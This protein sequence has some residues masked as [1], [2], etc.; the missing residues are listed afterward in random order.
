MA[1]LTMTRRGWATSNRESRVRPASACRR[2]R[3]TRRDR[4]EGDPGPV[5]LGLSIAVDPDEPA[6]GRARD[7]PHA[8]GRHRPDAG[9][10][11]QTVP[12]RRRTGAARC[13]RAALVRR[14]GSSDTSS[15]PPRSNPRLR[16]RSAARCP[17]YRFPTLTSASDSATCATT[18]PLPNRRRERGGAPRRPL[19]ARRGRRARTRRTPARGRRASGASTVTPSREEQRRASIGTHVQ[20]R[21]RPE[22]LR[23]PAA[24]SA[25]ATAP[26][27]AAASPTGARAASSSDSVSSC[28]TRRKRPAPSETR[29]AISC[30]RAA[31]RARSMPPRLA[32]ASSS[33]MTDNRHQEHSG[34][35]NCWVQRRRESRARRGDV[36]FDLPPLRVVRRRGRSISAGRARAC[37]PAPARSRRRL[38]PRD[39]REPAL[40]R[41]AGGSAPARGSQTS[42][43]AAHRPRR[44]N[45][46]RPRPRPS[47]ATDSGRRGSHDVDVAP[48]ARG[49]PLNWLLPVPPAHD[50]RGAGAGRRRKPPARGR[51]EAARRAPGR[52]CP[53]TTS[54]FRVRAGV[55]GR[56]RQRARPATS[57]KTVLRP[58]NSS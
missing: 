37:P 28:R 29:R 43:S 39:Q 18:R 2:W 31:P 41:I 33:R 45:P 12:A 9:N 20:I 3:S 4:I 32:Q 23:A 52:S 30:W 15:T 7:W 6:A 34:P 26:V 49:S 13:S 50:R 14:A 38:E 8:T 56:R 54:A 19:A 47:R 48:R 42:G 25:A 27:G 40:D 10:R 11:P 44:E 24:W 36:D 16:P 35:P 55:D 58:R 22:R 21:R 51:R 57:E 53:V 5:G 17:T 46:A 1:S